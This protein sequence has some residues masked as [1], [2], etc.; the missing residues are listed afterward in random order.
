MEVS[1][2]N[3]QTSA[4]CRNS[5]TSTLH[6]FREE[7]RQGKEKLTW[8]QL[9]FR[10]PASDF[11]SLPAAV[12]RFAVSHHDQSTRSPSCPLVHQGQVEQLLTHSFWKLA[13]NLEHFTGD[14]MLLKAILLSNHALYNCLA[15]STDPKFLWRNVCPFKA[16]GVVLWA[17]V[18]KGRI[19]HL[20]W[21]HLKKCQKE[22]QLFKQQKRER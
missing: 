16:A 3:Y 8:L 11:G 15:L 21:T 5:S 19:G 4:N 7:L 1:Q 6:S 13:C 22:V 20:P 12:L 17:R 14:P 18:I 9:Y 10:H 2:V